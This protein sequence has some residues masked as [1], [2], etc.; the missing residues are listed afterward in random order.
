M[1]RIYLIWLVVALAPYGF[2]TSILLIQTPDQIV[3]LAADSLQVE[4]PSGRH[5]HICK[6]QRS[7][8]AYWAA[9][10]NFYKTNAGFSVEG[11]WGP[12][13]DYLSARYR[14][15][16]ANPVEVIDKGLDTASIRDSTK[17]VEGPYS[18]LRLDKDGAEWIQ[19]GQCKGP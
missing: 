19:G 3:Y 5:N 10:S 7:G 14:D 13:A 12:A 2:A 11:F 16:S 4:R 15:F 6:I 9:A 17:G 1:R 8:N 18:I